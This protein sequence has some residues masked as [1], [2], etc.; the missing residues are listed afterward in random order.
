MLAALNLFIFC[1]LGTPADIGNQ[2][3]GFLF[4]LSNPSNQST[5][6][7]P[8]LQ[9]KTS[10]RTDAQLGPSFGQRDLE[11]F[12][13]ENGRLMGFSG[14]GASFNL[15]EISPSSSDARNYFAGSQQFYPDQVEVFYYHGKL[16][17]DHI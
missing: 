14:L 3:E 7:F 10:A 9:G 17:L 6:F 1:Y 2:F 13:D 16:I 12:E 11:L 5:Q 15:T 8:I 4:S